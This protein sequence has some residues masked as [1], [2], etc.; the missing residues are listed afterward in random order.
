[1]DYQ[2]K[3]ALIVTYVEAKFNEFMP[4]PDV[5]P[6]K[7]FVNE[8]LDFDKYNYD[9]TLFFQF[10]QY[11]YE[12]LTFNSKLETGN[13]RIFIVVRNDKEQALHERLRQYASAFWNMFEASR[14][15]FSG[16]VDIG[17]ITGVNFFDAAEG[18]SGIKL[19]EITMSLSKETI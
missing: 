7:H 12:E 11:A 6:V 3:E 17:M 1:V 16:I 2:E 15:C 19:A 8:F 9:N 4:S 18:N 14:Y 13:M 10:D 5:P